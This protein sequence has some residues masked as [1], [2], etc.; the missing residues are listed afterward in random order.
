MKILFKGES[1]LDK[2][3]RLEKEKLIISS[4]NPN[5][6][7]NQHPDTVVQKIDNYRIV[8]EI[9]GERFGSIN[10]A[11]KQLKVSENSIRRKLFNQQP[12]YI[13]IEKIRQGYEHIITNGKYYVSIKSPIQAG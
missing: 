4:Y 1:F 11:S 5:Q 2:K 7:Y 8:C 9:N 13:L 12:G 6:V 10:Q 3:K